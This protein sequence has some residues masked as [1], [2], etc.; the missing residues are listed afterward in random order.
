LIGICPGLNDHCTDRTVG[1]TDGFPPDG[2]DGTSS[3]AAIVDQ[4]YRMA[5]AL[6]HQWLGPYAHSEEFA[7]AVSS[8]SSGGSSSSSSSSRRRRNSGIQ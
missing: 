5:L 3:A 2:Q 4:A 8:I 7:A 1:G 6:V